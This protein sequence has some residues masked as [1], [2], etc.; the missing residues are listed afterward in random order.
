M[1][2]ATATATAMADLALIGDLLLVGLGCGCG[3]VRRRLARRCRRLQL[4]QGLETALLPLDG[5]LALRS[6][7]RLQ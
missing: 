6:R 4:V 5:L 7:S 2:A 1:T 3:I